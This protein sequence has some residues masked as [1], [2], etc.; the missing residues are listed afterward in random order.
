[1]FLSCVFIN[2]IFVFL[3]SAQNCNSGMQKRIHFRTDMEHNICRPVNDSDVSM[4]YQFCKNITFILYIVYNVRYNNAKYTLSYAMVNNHVFLTWL[5]WR[6]SRVEQDLPTLPEHPSSSPVILVGLCYSIFS[7]MCMFC[8]LL[9]I[10]LHFFFWPLC[11]L[12]FFNLRIMITSL[13]SS[14]SSLFLFK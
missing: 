10:L 12:F 8:R 5:T 4:G 9:F 2:F 6:R 13:V 3:T 1:V 7:F 11:C 14:N